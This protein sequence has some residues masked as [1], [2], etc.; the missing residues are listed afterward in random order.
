VAEVTNKLEDRLLCI[1][2]QDTERDVV[3]MP[4][5]HL[6][7]CI[8]CAEQQSTCPTCREPIQ[9]RLKVCLT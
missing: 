7:M 2:C 3:L 9:R 8:G 1:V 4:C 6:G 5:T